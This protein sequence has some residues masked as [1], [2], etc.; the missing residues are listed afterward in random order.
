MYEYLYEFVFKCKT[1][2]MKA[3]NTVTP[4]W[5]GAGCDYLW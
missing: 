2:Q 1:L 3:I 4:G 5:V